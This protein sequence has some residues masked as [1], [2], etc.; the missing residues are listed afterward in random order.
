MFPKGVQRPILFINFSPLYFRSML[1][2][3]FLIAD[4]NYAVYDSQGNIIYSSLPELPFSVAD[5]NLLT[6]PSSE[7]KGRDHLRYLICQKALGNGC[8]WS[9]AAIAPLKYAYSYFSDSLLILALLVLLFTTGYCVVMV[10]LSTRS[11]AKP[12]AIL[13]KAIG[14]T[15]EGDFG[16]RIV[17]TEHSDFQPIFTS[18]NQMNDQ[19]NQLIRENYEIKLNEKNLEIQVINLQFNPHFIYNTLNTISLLTMNRGEDDIS[20]MICSLSYMMRYS[21]KVPQGLV[22]FSKDRMQ[23]RFDPPF[24]YQEK[25]DPA[26]LD[27]SMPKFLLQPFIENAILHGFA[28]HG[29]LYTLSIEGKLED[30][31]ISFIICDDGEGMNEETL[32]QLW[33]KNSDSLGIRNTNHR[34]KLYYGEQFGVT[35]VSKPE[36]GTT[37][38]LVLPNKLEKTIS[39]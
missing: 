17:T 35:I 23:L 20:E 34:I 15:A 26:L 18:Y 27:V 2:T 24:L 6:A 3:D 30:D 13:T 38:T 12:F 9:V 4:T 7:M 29:K 25:I 21:I 32:K 36:R 19:V 28:N 16:Y 14:H 33:D 37:V 31:V 5:L 8:G 22:P 1:S 39:D 11:F 10:A